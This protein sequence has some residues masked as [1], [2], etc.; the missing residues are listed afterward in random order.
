L[1]EIIIDD[2]FRRTSTETYE[3]TSIRDLS[4]LVYAAQ[5]SATSGLSSPSELAVLNGN[6]MFALK[7]N[8]VLFTTSVA[9]EYHGV[10]Y[11]TSVAA[12]Y[13]GAICATSVAAEYHEVIY[14]T[15]VAAEYRGVIYA[16]SVAAKYREVIYA[17]SVAA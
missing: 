13:H 9:A 17:T 2:E 4:K 10:I 7:Y 1:H 11:T 12:K 16:T 5:L 3:L 8:G 6:C 15:S 14:A